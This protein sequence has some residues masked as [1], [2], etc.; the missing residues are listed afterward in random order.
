MIVQSRVHGGRGL[1]VFCVDPGETNGWAWACLGW[2]ELRRE[3]IKGALESAV[4]H[5]SGPLLADR[6]FLCGQIG[7]DRSEVG[8]CN[9]AGALFDMAV[10]C[11]EMGAR[12]SLVNGKSLVPH[13][14][15]L[16]VE[17]FILRLQTQSRDLL[18]PVR[19]SARLAV[20]AHQ[21]QWQM[22]WTLQSPSDKGVITDDRLRSHGLWIVGQQHARDACRHLVLHL[23]KVMAEDQKRHRNLARS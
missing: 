10:V 13:L 7:G 3:G 17:D 14:T 9:S 21:H 2:A 5:R 18:S 11:G 22:T 16:V 12:T 4:R 19:Q 15:D 23:R 20:L 6:R 8:E 1:S